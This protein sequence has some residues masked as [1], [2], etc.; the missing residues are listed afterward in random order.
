MSKEVLTKDISRIWYEGNY[1]AK[2]YKGHKLIWPPDYLKH[3]SI[4]Y[5]FNQKTGEFKVVQDAGFVEYL[6]DNTT[7]YLAK[8][9]EDGTVLAIPLYS[10]PNYATG[11]MLFTADKLGFGSSNREVFYKIDKTKSIYDTNSHIDFLTQIPTIYFRCKEIDEDLFDINFSTY[12]FDGC[13]EVFGPERLIGLFSGESYNGKW[14]SDV[15]M[16]YG[17]KPTF[18]ECREHIANKGKGWYGA[19]SEEIGVLMML[20]MFKSGV[21]GQ[22]LTYDY[23][24]FGVANPFCNGGNGRNYMP[25]IEIDPATNIAKVSHLDGGVEYLEI[26]YIWGGSF[27]KLYWGEYLSIIPKT[28]GNGIYYTNNQCWMGNHKG[29]SLYLAYGE[30]KWA[31]AGDRDDTDIRNMDDQLRIRACYHGDYVVTN[32]IKYF[33][34]LPIL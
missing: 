23:A 5:T 1:Y 28:P 30:G 22:C 18:S 4:E 2:M 6:L 3:E 7:I 33:E 17:F 25:N 21:N 11:G 24:P 26:P 32:D 20:A 10:E 8:C 31:I 16:M 34:E 29:I 13:H 27:S 12:P 19:Y 14:Y 15:N 9:R